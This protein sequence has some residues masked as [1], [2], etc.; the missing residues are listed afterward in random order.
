MRRTSVN[1]FCTILLGPPLLAIITISIYWACTGSFSG[2]SVEYN[3][4]FG[5]YW[6]LQKPS[7][8]HRPNPQPDDPTCDPW[9]SPSHLYLNTTHPL[10]SRLHTYNPSC[11]PASPPWISQIQSTLQT[12][13]PIPALANKE[14][15]L[16]GDSVDRRILFDLCNATLGLPFQSRSLYNFSEPNTNA[17]GGVPHTC[18][19]PQLNL[20]LSNFFFYG[21]DETDMFKGLGPYCPPGRFTERFELLKR[22]LKTLPSGGT[23]DLVVVNVGLWELLRHHVLA[24]RTDAVD[25]LDLH[26]DFQREFLDNAVKFLREIR[27]A[28]GPKPR[29]RFR[30]NHTPSPSPNAGDEN[31]ITDEK[32]A[33]GKKRVRYTSV[34]MGTLNALIE[35]AVR[36]ANEEGMDVGMWF[37]GRAMRVW[38]PKMWVEDDCHPK[39]GILAGVWGEGLLEMVARAPRL[40]KV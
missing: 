25:P 8:S 9:S 4:K 13:T 14:V 3:K 36:R 32:V 28:I 15:L 35:E 11:Q 31:F 30:E 23:P 29:I 5:D 37:V 27:E 40:K 7:T 22:T 6:T 33:N 10:S 16:V 1:R 18:S 12:K 38:P 21:F 39:K 2:S 34:R 20:T 19:I 24:E 17:T 26:E